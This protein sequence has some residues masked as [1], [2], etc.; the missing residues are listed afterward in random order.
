MIFVQELAPGM[1][2]VYFV[3]EFESPYRAAVA[4]RRYRPEECT[5]L[6]NTLSRNLSDGVCHRGHGVVWQRI[7]LRAV[8]LKFLTLSRGKTQFRKT[9]KTN[10]DNL[11]GDST[12]TDDKAADHHTDGTAPTRNVRNSQQG[13][14]SFFDNSVRGPSRAQNSPFPINSG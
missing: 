14:R 5:T 12:G 9:L 13:Q 10:C 8:W 1:A 2:I 7:P 11:P 4:D 6:R 3:V